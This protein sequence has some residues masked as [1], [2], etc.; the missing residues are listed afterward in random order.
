MAK[1]VTRTD[2][3]FRVMMPGDIITD[4]ATMQEALEL[5]QLGG[6]YVGEVSVKREM[7]I[8]D[9]VKYSTV[10]A[11]KSNSDSYVGEEA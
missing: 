3:V 8:E 6:A 11:N 10:S 5:T 1:K 9:W 4:C 7:Y 2:K